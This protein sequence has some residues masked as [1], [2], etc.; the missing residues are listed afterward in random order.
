MCVIFHVYRIV[1][2]YKIVIN[3]RK[4][5]DIFPSLCY[6]DLTSYSYKE[7]AHEI[8][9][10]SFCRAFHSFNDVCATTLHHFPHRRNQFKNPLY[11]RGF[12]R[13]GIL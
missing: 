7:H 1:K 6:N 8:Q 5:I 2:I 3:F 10:I 4:P 12:A 9:K 13:F 11:R